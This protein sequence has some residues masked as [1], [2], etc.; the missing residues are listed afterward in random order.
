MFSGQNQTEKEET[1]SVDNA[2]KPRKSLGDAFLEKIKTQEGQ[3]EDNIEL[4]KPRKSLGDAFL[5]KIRTQEGQKEE[6]QVT[7]IAAKR[8]GK[9]SIFDK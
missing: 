8:A 4:N 9:G 7:P 5:E 2:N 6:Q 1:S 3:K